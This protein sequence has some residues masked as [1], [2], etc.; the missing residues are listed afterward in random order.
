MALLAIVPRLKVL[1]FTFLLVSEKLISAV[2]H[3]S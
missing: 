3:D 2:N 1:S